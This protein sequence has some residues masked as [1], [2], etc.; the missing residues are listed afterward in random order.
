MSSIQIEDFP[1]LAPGGGFVPVFTVSGTQ[2][3][4]PLDGSAAVTVSIPTFVT[5]LTVTLTPNVPTAL[6][7]ILTCEAIIA[8]SGPWSTFQIYVTGGQPTTTGPIGWSA[9]GS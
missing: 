5:E 6:A 2:A 7:E 9:Q 4:V 1:F 3:N 8:A